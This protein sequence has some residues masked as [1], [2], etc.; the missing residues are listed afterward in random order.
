MAAML[1]AVARPSGFHRQGSVAIAPH[2]S[3]G[4]CRRQAIHRQYFFTSD[5]QRT[6]GD[7]GT[8]RSQRQSQ[9]IRS[10]SRKRHAEIDQHSTMPIGDAGLLG[11]RRNSRRYGLAHRLGVWRE[12]RTSDLFS[13]TR[14]KLDAFW[15]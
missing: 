6:M 3:E 13:W 15:R 10:A 14:W 11:L 9:E 12:K 1:L 7:G 2:A 5:E 8:W 4:P